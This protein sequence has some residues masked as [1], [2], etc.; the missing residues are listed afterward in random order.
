MCDLVL[1]NDP[2][3][4]NKKSDDTKGKI[5]KE[6]NDKLDITKT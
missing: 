6:K 4:V 2:T 5:I 3:L 1:R